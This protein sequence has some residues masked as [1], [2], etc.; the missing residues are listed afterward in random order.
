MCVPLER[1]DLYVGSGN[2]ELAGEL[3]VGDVM[4]QEHSA[5]L[6][7]TRKDKVQKAPSQQ[8]KIEVIPA[9]EGL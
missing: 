5:E 7:G 2:P 8:E 9:R 4:E 3:G 1:S 6:E